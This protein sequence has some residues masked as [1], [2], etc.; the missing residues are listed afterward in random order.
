MNPGIIRTLVAKDFSLFFRNRFYAAVTA[1]GIVTY[2]IIYFVLPGAVNEN[3]ELGLYAPDLPPAFE[4]IQQEGI[5]IQA[6][7]SEEM[8]VEAVTE[9]EY[10]AGVVLPAD[11]MEKFAS[12]QKPQITLYFLADAAEAVQ[13]AVEVMI[14][15]L[16]YLQTEQP[17]AVDISAKILGPDRL[18][19]QIPTRDRMRPMLAIMI[20]MFETMGLASLIS[21]EV[22]HG[23]ARALLVTPMKV[24]HLFLAKGIMGVS[25]AFGQAVLFMAIVGGLENQP[26][27][28]LA[29]LLLGGVLATGAG[30]LVASL[31][32]D[33][34]SV[35]AWGVPIIIILAVPAFGILF[36]GTVSSWVKAIP[37]F[38]LVDTVHRVAN[39]GAGWGDIWS[40]LLIL[41]GFNLVLVWG[42]ILALGRKFR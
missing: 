7:D 28:I 10:A 2:T 39:F 42:G 26:L 37:S 30:F 5:T 19:E 8:L 9:G 11:I 31:A 1:L 33:M 29:A 3:L 24:Q 23:T 21:E 34:M 27:I 36:P 41:L 25:L 15:E 17:L 20:I 18:G 40:N 12:G 6:F 14:R 35:M 4:L 13:D 16:A 32:K 22:E 38:Y